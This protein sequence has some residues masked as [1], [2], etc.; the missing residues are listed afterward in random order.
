ME[1]SQ[2]LNKIGL[3][4]ERTSNGLDYDYITPGLNKKELGGLHISFDETNEV[5]Q[6]NQGFCYSIQRTDRHLIYSIINTDYKDNAKRNGFYAIRLIVKNN[7]FIDNV[8]VNLGQVTHI[9]VAHLNANTL[10]NQNYESILNQIAGDVKRKY[11]IT[12]KIELDRVVYYQFINLVE[13]QTKLFNNP[14]LSYANKV[15]FLN[16]KVSQSDGTARQFGFEPLSTYWDKTKEIQFLNPDRQNI[17]L[18]INAESFSVSMDQFLLVCKALDV[19]NFKTAQER[20]LTSVSSSEKQ[21]VIHKQQ[22]ESY[23]PKLNL[24]PSQFKKKSST[25]ALLWIMGI[26]IGILGGYFGR[27]IVEDFLVLNEPT[28]IQEPLTDVHIKEFGIQIDTTAE[29]VIHLIAK[30]E[31]LNNFVFKYDGHKSEKW[32]YMNKS[33]PTL[34]RLT[35][36]DLDS[37]LNNDAQRINAFKEELRNFTSTPIPQDDRRKSEGEKSNNN[38]AKTENIS[39]VKTKD[40]KNEQKGQTTKGNTERK[41]TGSKVEVKETSTSKEIGSVKNATKKS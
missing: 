3:V 26:A 31:H 4:I 11:W 34:N 33:K 39:S 38:A 14:K 6:F 32:Y 10:N 23:S 24:Y 13:N 30:G 35:V 2:Y 5:G 15:Y 40:A 19:V 28:V 21:V 36:K 1:N 25:S 27:P 37:L 18:S 8:Y 17:S 29:N 9:Y 22:I 16:D 7:E 20:Q 12:P 41:S